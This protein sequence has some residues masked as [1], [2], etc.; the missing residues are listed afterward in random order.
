MISLPLG[1][2]RLTQ[3]YSGAG[4]RYS[5]KNYSRMEEHI[6]KKLPD[7]KGLDIN[8]DTTVVGVGGTLRAMA[9]Y[10]Q[11]IKKYPLDKI[12]NYRI[13]FDHIQSI[14]STLRKMT[15]NEIAKIDTVGSNRAETITAGS[16]I[17]KVLLQKLEFEN[18]LVSAQGLREGVLSAFLQS[19]KGYYSQNINQT[20]IQ[21]YVKHCSQTRENSRIYLC[22]SQTTLLFRPNERTRI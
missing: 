18:I 17:M 11:E 19:S 10:D 1:A 15:S 8:P 20:Q 22:A 16:C 13:D 2:L 9:R 21:R 4:G 14:N 3:F 7:R 6:I 12:H 5:K